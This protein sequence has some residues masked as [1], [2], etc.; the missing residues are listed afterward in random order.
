M[1]IRIKP[2]HR[3][4][5]TKWCKKHGFDGPTRDCIRAALRIAK[6]RHDTKLKK[7]AIFARN[8]KRRF[9]PSRG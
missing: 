5:F 7:R 1:A 8:A 6:K 4:L 2:S 3:G 9:K